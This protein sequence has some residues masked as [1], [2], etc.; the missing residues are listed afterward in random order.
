MKTGACPK[1]SSQDVR[2]GA[3]IKKKEKIVLHTGEGILGPLRKMDQYV[4]V[5][6]GYVE[7]YLEDVE[8]LAYIAQHWP[9]VI[10]D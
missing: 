10:S 8:G 6:C 7:T 9:C 3:G 5:N 2:S 1:C 4:C